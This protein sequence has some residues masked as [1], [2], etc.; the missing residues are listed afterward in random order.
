VIAITAKRTVLAYFDKHDPGTAC[1]FRKPGSINEEFAMKE[2]IVSADEV[3]VT[4]VRLGQED[5]KI[6]K[7]LK[8]VVSL[9]NFER[10]SL[11]NTFVSEMALKGAPAEFI[12][13]I[14][15]LRDETIAEK[16]KILIQTRR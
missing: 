14:A 2:G 7:F 15:A 8:A 13:A 10:Q 9:D 6:S 5:E 12:K 16:V 11:V 4:L 3:F 1:R